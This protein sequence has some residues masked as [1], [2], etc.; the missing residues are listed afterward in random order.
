MA[1]SLRMHAPTQSHVLHCQFIPRDGNRFPPHLRHHA[2]TA[3]NTSPD[4]TTSSDLSDFFD[5]LTNALPAPGIMPPSGLAQL[6][7]TAV[8]ANRLAAHPNAGQPPLPSHHYCDQ[9][10]KPVRFNFENN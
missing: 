1:A 3:G 9:G 5:Q 8:A 6:L 10:I 2:K 4:K 7:K